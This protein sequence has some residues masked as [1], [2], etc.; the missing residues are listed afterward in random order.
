[1]L[2]PLAIFYSE[3]N[4]GRCSQW[5]WL[6]AQALVPPKNHRAEDMMYFKSVKAQSPPIRWCHSLE[7]SADSGV[8]LVI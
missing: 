4:L 1:M 3:P 7:K 2:F 5:L 6:R 8:V